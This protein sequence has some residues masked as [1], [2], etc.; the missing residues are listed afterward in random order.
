[1]SAIAKYEN[2]FFTAENNDVD[3]F[4]VKGKAKRL[5]PTIADA[6]FA[7]QEA[8]N[9][10]PK[11]LTQRTVTVESTPSQEKPI[12]VQA[13]SSSRSLLSRILLAIVLLIAA[14]LSIMFVALL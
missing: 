14:I 12:E 2:S 5:E 7:Q 10:T 8:A 1:M 9:K 11:P 3:P 4:T 13:E 6:Y